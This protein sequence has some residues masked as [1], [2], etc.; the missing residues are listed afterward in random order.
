MATED[1]KP[2]G[3]DELE[4]VLRRAIDASTILPLRMRAALALAVLDGEH[5]GNLT[6]KS[7][8]EIR[9]II[10]GDGE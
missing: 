6:P 1:E 7:I 4:R 9:R 2:S 8:T 3:R 5:P 10:N